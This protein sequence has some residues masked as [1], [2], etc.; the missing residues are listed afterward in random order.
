MMNL[1]RVFTMTLVGA[2]A[3]LIAFSAFAPT[4]TQAASQAISEAAVVTNTSTTA[5]SGSSALMQ[6]DDTQRGGENNAL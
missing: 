2:T 6:T 3:G 1:K 5:Q 4:R